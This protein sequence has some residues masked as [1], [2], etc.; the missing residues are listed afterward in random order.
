ML[1]ITKA[2]ENDTT[3]IY[4]IEGK[5]T[6]ETLD[7]WTKEIQDLKKVTQRQIILDLCQVWFIHAK[8]IKV[9]VESMSADIYL[10][11]CSMEVRNLLHAAG[12]S[13]RVLE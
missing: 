1:R 7:M 8:A 5:V 6:D 2:F 11:N 4:K 12:L 3:V 9:L 13:K 10:L